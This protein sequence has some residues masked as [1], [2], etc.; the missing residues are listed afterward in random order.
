MGRAGGQGWLFVFG[1]V[2]VGQLPK[3][4]ARLRIVRWGGRWGDFG[5]NFGGRWGERGGVGAG[6]YL[7]LYFARMRAFWRRC[8][9]G[10]GFA[11]VWCVVG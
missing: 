3:K 4:F 2:C 5:E 6:C 9:R 8:W 1:L 7:P 10:W 11:I